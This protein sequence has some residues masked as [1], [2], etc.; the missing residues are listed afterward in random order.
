MHEEK[1]QLGLG[2]EVER[3]GY[4]S[5]AEVRAGRRGSPRA[6]PPARGGS[7]AS[8]S[9]SSSPRPGR[10]SG[11]SDEFA[12]ALARGTGVPVRILSSEEEGMLAWDGAVA[13]L[14]QPPDSVAVCDVGGG[15]H[16]SWS[17][18]SPPGRPG[19]ARSTSARSG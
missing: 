16:S 14:E 9:R 18:R 13:A 4:I 12:D 17:A 10:Q 2:E 3:Y 19:C 11:N 5:A 8:G 6:D 15:S 1:E 7:A